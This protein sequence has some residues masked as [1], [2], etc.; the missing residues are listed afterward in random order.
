MKSVLVEE[1]PTSVIADD[2]LATLED[3]R[4]VVLKRPLILDD[5]GSEIAVELVEF[6]GWKEGER[7]RSF[8]FSSEDVHSPGRGV[9]KIPMAFSSKI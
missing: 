3:A 9:A 7:Q 8:Q 6:L 4:L 5:A 2:V 1:D